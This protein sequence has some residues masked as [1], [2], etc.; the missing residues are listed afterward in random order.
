[1]SFYQPNTIP[2]WGILQLAVIGIYFCISGCSL[3]YKVDDECSIDEDCATM[4]PPNMVCS[5]HLCVSSDDGDDSTT[6]ASNTDTGIGTETDTAGTDQPKRTGL[7]LL[8]GPCNRIDGMTDVNE[9]IPEDAII[10]GS[11]LPITGELSIAGEHFDQATLL[12]VEEINRA[13]GILGRPLIKVACD[14]GTSPETAIQAANHLRDI[15]VQAVL[16]PFSSE[17]VLSVFNATFRDAGILLV[18][19]GANAPIISTVSQEGLIWS[20]SLPASREAAVMAEYVQHSNLSKVAVIHRGDTWGDSMFNA[21]FTTY[22]ENTAIDCTDEQSMM[23]RSYATD[24]LTT[25]LSSVVV[26]LADWQPEIV[27]HFTYVED[28]LTFMSINGAVG[29]PVQRILW[30]STAASDLI[31][32]LL[33]EQLH[34][35][36]CQSESVVQQTPSGIIYSS[37][38]T[39]YRA[40][41]DGSD[42]IPYTASFYDAAYILAYGISAAVSNETANP[43]GAA[44]SAAMHRL[45]S[46]TSIRVGAEDWNVGVMAL[47]AED[48]A[49][50]DFTG[51]SGEVDFDESFFAVHFTRPIYAIS[52]C[53]S[54]KG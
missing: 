49:T 37:F 51:A 25:S 43:T 41:F 36:L 46:G 8:A 42:P 21:F 15:G 32:P 12:A 29:A 28:A 17:I 14:S 5:H 16:G 20:T 4:S 33:D 48:A 30:N 54:E 23:V 19:A 6:G 24:D 45:S 2:R 1:M 7:D 27:V 22:C 3:I 53:R 39:R 52:V 44:V 9:E 47:Q 13:G 38:L 35:T 40:R 34:P 50:I 26:E 31:F 18:S 10:I 11:I